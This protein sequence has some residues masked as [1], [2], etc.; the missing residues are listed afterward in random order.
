MDRRT[1]AWALNPAAPCTLKL[2]MYISSSGL[3]R[4]Q[5]PP[6]QGAVCIPLCTALHCASISRGPPPSLGVL[7]LSFVVARRHRHFASLGT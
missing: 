2:H 7:F 5:R 4:N 3:P 6:S 1:D